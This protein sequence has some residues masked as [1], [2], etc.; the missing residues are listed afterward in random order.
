MP[1]WPELIATRFTSTIMA[2]VNRYCAKA[3]TRWFLAQ[4]HKSETSLEQAL[5]DIDI[6]THL[7]GDCLSPRSAEEAIYEA[8]IV[9][10]SLTSAADL[11]GSSLRS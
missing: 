7:V 2:V 8:Y 10:R 11:F 3:P 9:A 1:V 6:D 5:R 4:G